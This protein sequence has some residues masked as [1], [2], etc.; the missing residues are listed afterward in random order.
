M[1]LTSCLSMA[2]MEGLTKMTVMKVIAVTELIHM[3][4][5]I[6][7]EFTT[8]LDYTINNRNSFAII[9]FNLSLTLSRFF[10]GDIVI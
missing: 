2:N 8:T 1:E 7:L 9:Q 3:L 6:D 5:I 4:Y 10:K